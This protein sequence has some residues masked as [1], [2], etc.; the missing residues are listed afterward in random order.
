MLHTIKQHAVLILL[1]S[2]L[3]VIFCIL[4]TVILVLVVAMMILIE[5][6]LL[7]LSQRRI[8]PMM[9]G[10]RGILQIVADVIKPLFKEIFELKLQ[11]ATTVAFSVFSYF[12]LQLLI[13]DLT[14]VSIASAAHTNIEFVIILQAALSGISCFFVLFIGYLSGSKYAIIGSIRLIVCEASSDVSYTL[15]NFIIFSASQG[16]EYDAI[17]LNQATTFNII[18]LAI[19]YGM[20]QLFNTFISAQRAPIDL[21]EVEGELVA[22]YNTE[23][24]GADVLVIYFSEYFHLFNAAVSFILLLLIGASQV[25]GTP[26]ATSLTAINLNQSKVGAILRGIALI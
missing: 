19:I 20:M 6:K 26:C 12:F 14:Q 15:I 9:L 16:A 24:S 11:A 21:I 1:S 23:Y 13:A 25:Y 5:R 17:I 18:L 7:A 2:K 22:G 4:Y 10:N 3:Y 8:G